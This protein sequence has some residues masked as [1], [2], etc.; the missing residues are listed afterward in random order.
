MRELQMIA[1][2]ALMTSAQSVFAESG[3][4]PSPSAKPADANA[5]DEKAPVSA[6]GMT[7]PEYTG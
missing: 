3:S 6:S 4:A 5:K 1:T 2:V 7:A